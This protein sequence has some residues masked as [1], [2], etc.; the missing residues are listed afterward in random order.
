MKHSTD[1]FCQILPA[2]L[3]SGKLWQVTASSGKVVASSSKIWQV[4][5][6][7]NRF[8]WSLLEDCVCAC[9]YIYILT[10]K[11]PNYLVMKFPLYSFFFIYNILF[12]TRAIP[13]N[14]NRI[15]II[16]LNLLWSLFAPLYY[17]VLIPLKMVNELKSAILTIM[18]LV[19]EQ[20]TIMQQSFT[21]AL[22]Q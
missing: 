18:A 14:L 15:Y 5:A 4:L 11:T 3:T 10:T 7:S 22:V 1:K 2:W 16:L 19:K 9:V 13:L 20:M 12:F 17:I 8:Y 6:R 21:D